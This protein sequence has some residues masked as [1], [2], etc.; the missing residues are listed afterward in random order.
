MKYD[1][2]IL[3]GKT[4]SV[5]FRW[6]RSP[7]VYKP[8]TGVVSTTPLRLTAPAHGIPDGWPAAIVSTVGLDE[9][10][11]TNNPPRGFEYLQATV[12]DA[13]TIEFNQ[14]NAA[15]YVPYVSGGF[16]QYYT[17]IDLTGYTARMQIR[18]DFGGAAIIS[19]ASPTQ[20]VLDTATSTIT[21]S[22]DAVTTGAVLSDQGVYDL[23]AVSPT[24]E[25]SRI[26]YGAV[27]FSPEVTT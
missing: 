21:V 22:I 17:P 19:L 7:V 18:D 27:I 8:I 4:F 13:D 2:N 26:A 10:R 24:G 15:S 9:I 1:L 25:V 16:L 5:S 20:I 6:A 14:V 12:V 3:V 23:E 11:A